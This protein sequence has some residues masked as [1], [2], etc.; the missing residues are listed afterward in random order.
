[1]HVIVHNNRSVV[2]SSPPLATQ[3]LMHLQ[4]RRRMQPADESLVT[5]NSGGF[6]SEERK[7]LLRYVFCR[8]CISNPPESGMVDKSNILPHQHTE[9]ILVAVFHK[10]QEQIS[11]VG[12]HHTT[13]NVLP[14]KNR[15]N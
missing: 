15:T 3:K 11:V 7:N 4:S 13:M 8:V 6:L 9:S 2:S 12:A 14:L 10:S 1:V 5:A